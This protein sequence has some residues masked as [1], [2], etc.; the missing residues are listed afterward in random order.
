MIRR[1]DLVAQRDRPGDCLVDLQPGSEARF[2]LIDLPGVRSPLSGMRAHSIRSRSSLNKT[3][4]RAQPGRRLSVGEDRLGRSRGG[5]RTR[6]HVVVDAQGLP[7]RLGL[8]AGQAHNVQIADKLLD[9]LRARTIVL[10]GKAYD[11]DRIRALI[12]ERDATLN[13][14]AKSNRKWKPCFSWRLYRELNLLERFFNKLSHF[15]PIVTGYDK[16]PEISSP[17]SSSPQCACGSA[18]I[19]LRPSPQYRSREA[20]RRQSQ[21]R[22]AAALPKRVDV[23]PMQMLRYPL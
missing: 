21:V 17:W 4:P 20:K 10:A 19:S 6:T 14:P 7:I 3:G 18:L 8:T 22:A 9:R 15:R 2:A 12:E 13:I 16:L 1:A 5:L 11:A 23:W